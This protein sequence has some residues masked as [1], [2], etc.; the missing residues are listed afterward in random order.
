MTADTLLFFEE[1]EQNNNREWFLDNK[2]RWENIRD[3]FIHLTSQ[4]ID[5]LSPIDPTIGHPDPKRCLYRIYRDLRFT[6]DKRPYKTHISFFLSSGGVKR[7]GAPGYY[8]QIGQ[9]DYGLQTGCA[10]GGGIFMPDPQSLAAIRQEIYYCYDEFSQIIAQH[11][12]QKYFGNT[13]FTTGKLTRAPKG[14]P[15]DWE[16]VDWLKYKDYC[17]MASLPQKE[18]EKDNLVDSVIKI[19][20]ASVPLNRFI[21]RAMDIA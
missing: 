1:L 21:Q 16:G 15:N 19:F 13:F 17:T 11:T 5:R 12:Y 6:A 10:L 18:I 2:T 3:D 20:E 7:S 9:S 4:V 8:M 14:Y